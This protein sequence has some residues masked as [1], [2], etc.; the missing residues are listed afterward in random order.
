MKGPLSGDGLD[1]GRWAGCRIS[2]PRIRPS[3][4]S[5]GAGTSFNP[6]RHSLRDTLIIQ[7]FLATYLALLPFYDKVRRQV[8]FWQ[9]MDLPLQ[10]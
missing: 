8:V 10:I 6:C 3:A 5:L 9:F 1:T 7:I 4:L 2:T